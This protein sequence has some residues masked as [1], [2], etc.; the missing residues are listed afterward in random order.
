MAP[1]AQPKSSAIET[2]KQLTV[3]CLQFL[4]CHPA[5]LFEDAP[6]DINEFDDFFQESFRILLQCF[7]EPDEDILE[8]VSSVTRKLLN[9]SNIFAP[10]KGPG[11]KPKDARQAFWDST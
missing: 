1:V 11:I 2:R 9:G 5:A 4:H 8:I 3:C 7:R 10:L 6:A